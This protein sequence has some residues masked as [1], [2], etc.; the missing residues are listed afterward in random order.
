LSRHSFEASSWLQ[1][2]GP[3]NHSVTTEKAQVMAKSYREDLSPEYFDPSSH[4]IP[5]WKGSSLLSKPA[6]LLNNLIPLLSTDAREQ[7][8]TIQGG[9]SHLLNLYN[10]FIDWAQFKE[11]SFTLDNVSIFVQHFKD[12]NSPYKAELE[13]FQKHYSFRAVVKYLLKIKFLTSLSSSLEIHYT[14]ENL[15][16]PTSFLV[17]IFQGGGSTELRC[18]SL[19][20]SPYSWYRPGREFSE[21]LMELAS[22]F[23]QINITELTKVF[24]YREGA[25]SCGLLNLEDKN[26][27]HSLSHL[28]FGLFLNSLLVYLPDWIDNHKDTKGSSFKFKKISGSLE[29]LNTK[30]TGQK[31]SSLSLAHRLAQENNLTPDWS[32]I[33]CPDFVGNEFLSGK[34]SKI[35]Q[36]LLFLSFLIEVSK[37]RNENPIQLICRTFKD[38]NARGSIETN[39]QASFLGSLEASNDLIYERVVLNI[40]ELPKRNPHFALISQITN[41]LEEVEVGGLLFVMTNQNLFVPSQSERVKQLTKLAKLEVSFD[42]S[43]LKWRGEIPGHLYIFTKRGAAL[44]HHP[45]LGDQEQAANEDKEHCF[46]FTWSGDLKH[47]QMFDGLAKEFANFLK[48]KTPTTT[49]LFLKELDEGLVFEFHQDAIMDGKL[50]S[51]MSKDKEKITHPRFFKCLTNSSIPFDTFFHMQA[52]SPHSNMKEAFNDESGSVSESLLGLQYQPEYKY[53]NILVANFSN[54]TDIHIEIIDSKSYRATLENYGTAYYH[55]FGLTPKTSPLNI[56]LFREYFNHPMGHQVIQLSLSGG[57]TK[58]KPKL[59]SLLIPSFFKE[60]SL[61]PEN[62]E[63]CLSPLKL[64]RDQILSMDPKEFSKITYNMDSW[65]L[66]MG[67]KYPWYV[68]GLLSHFKFNVDE[69]INTMKGKQISGNIFDF[70][71]PLIIE[72]LIGL[73]SYSL[74]PRN[75]DAFLDFNI[76]SNQDIHLPLSDVKA[77]QEGSNHFLALIS[78]DDVIVKIYSDEDLLKFAKFILVSGIGRPISQLLT[79]IKLPR[80]TEFKKVLSEY[81][82]LSSEIEAVKTNTQSLLSQI[83]KNQILL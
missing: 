58:L 66:S 46:S 62:L 14:K 43:N 73:K 37:K 12:E 63:Q 29:V 51:S 21:K 15:L 32:K 1:P 80:V 10:E 11:L 7:L 34:F 65:V 79:K 69:V 59:K 68:S 47:F 8:K 41:Q 77:G 20:S 82:E 35:C 25:K 67:E 18:E 60:N 19:Q 70:Q 27:S 31:L 9:K 3:L 54:P 4:L 71:N 16:N 55:Y 50:M 53:R 48:D 24:T 56:N 61:P 74:F 81:S 28:S 76:S 22:S 44:P 49:P 42:F 26:Y 30:F 33:I 13:E 83:I 2:S 64:T 57:T 6:I 39:G 72:K 40:P 78:E 36:E 5:G 75:E 17:K 45:Y 38:K 23:D 52:I